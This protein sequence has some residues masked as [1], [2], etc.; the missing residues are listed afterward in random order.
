MVIH[1][2]VWGPSKVPT[3][4]GS[5]WFV[6]FINNAW[7]ID[8]GATDHMTFDSKQVSPLIPSSQKI[9]S[10]TNGNTTPIIGEGSLTLTDTL[11]WILF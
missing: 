8:S 2:D 4:S 9:V 7:I 5:R 6:T 11:I 3:L 10:T 1:Y